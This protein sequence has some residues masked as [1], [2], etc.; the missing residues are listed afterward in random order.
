[1][2]H[3]VL[4]TGASGFIGGHLVASLSE[5]G[6]PVRCLVRNPGFA[7][8]PGVEVVTGDLRD[9]GA[10]RRAVRGA[11]SVVHLAARVH[12]M[13]ERGSDA[14]DLYR[15]VNV[16][17]TRTLAV[18]AARAKVTRFVLASTVKAVAEASPTALTPDTEPRPPDA[19]GR[20]KLEAEHVLAA[21]LGDS[22]T[23]HVILR[24]P[25][26]YGPRMVGNMIRLFRW[27]DRGVP[28]PLAGV[29][30]RRTVAYVGNVVAALRHLLDL[31]ATR[32]EI[33]YAG[34][35]E[36]LSTPELIRA[37]GRAL[38]RPARL[39][40]CP[41]R[42]LGLVGAAGDAV[43]ALGLPAPVGTA[44]V[45][46]L[47]GSLWVDPAGLRDLGFE[48]ST[49]TARGLETTAAWYRAA[50]TEAAPAPGRA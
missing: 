35:P 43:R 41:P 30:N 47:V 38:G 34:D 32:G 42:V 13:D 6:V 17:G 50:G 21:T 4:V 39:V 29:D 1:M 18:E 9:P 23:E 40:P 2:T 49:S 45:E 20:T 8:G 16:E 19:Y 31:P 33:C 3:P 28:L 37:V 26:V 12:R 11:G 15:A 25:L 7:H 24:L 14:E 48:P 44:A 27:V 36:P 46:R 22:G 5:S 10:V